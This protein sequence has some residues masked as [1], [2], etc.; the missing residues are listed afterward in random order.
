MH[1]KSIVA[2]R[3]VRVF[4]LCGRYA[5][6]L[7]VLIRVQVN[8]GGGGKERRRLF[9]TGSPQKLNNLTIGGNDDTELGK[10]IEIIF[11]KQV[12]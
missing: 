2:I 6:H 3:K 9:F 11:T 1:Q 10:V 7:N 4:Q 8:P 5:V 12:D